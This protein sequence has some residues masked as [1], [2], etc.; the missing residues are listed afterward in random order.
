M[1]ITDIDVQKLLDAFLPIFATKQDLENYVT[2]NE[3]DEFKD[4]AYGKMDL[5]IGEL[6]T[7]RLEQA[8]HQL[9]HDRIQDRIERIEAVPVVAHELKK[10]RS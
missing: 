2:R 1:A 7:I 4:G 3:F 5:I 10:N 8:T 9:N 6:K